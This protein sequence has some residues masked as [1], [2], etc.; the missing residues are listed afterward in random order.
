[1]LSTKTLYISTLA[2]AG[3]AGF[4]SGWAAKPEQAVRMDEEA[5]TLRNWE[6][7]YVVDDTDRENLRELFRS[8]VADRKEL[9][10]EVRP[11]IDAR[12]RDLADRYDSQVAAILT[13]SK[14]RK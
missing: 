4:T 5:V 7:H 2:L 10:E 3:A 1:M 12:V 9:R 14:R 13:E 11:L 8:F 6:Q